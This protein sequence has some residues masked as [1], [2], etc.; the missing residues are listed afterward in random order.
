MS[1]SKIPNFMIIGAAKCGTTTLHHLFSQHPQIYLPQAKETHFFDLDY[2]YEKGKSFYLNTYYSKVN[3]QHK[4]IGDATP[5]YLRFPSKVIPRIK[6]TIGDDD[7]K[8]FVMLR[9]P[10]QR[11]WSHYLHTVRIAEETLDFDEALRLESQRLEENPTKWV[12]YFNDGLYAQQLKPWLEHYPRESFRI[13]KLDDL[14]DNAEETL[15]I[16]FDFLEVDTRTS[17]IDFSGKNLRQTMRSPTLM[18]LIR[19]KFQG[20]Q[21]IK[22]VIPFHI[23]RRIVDNL[24]SINARVV[25]KEETLLGSDLANQLRERYRPSVDELETLLDRDFSQWK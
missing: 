17:S 24:V 13:F 14:K 3:K 21:L 2:Q 9:D 12:G 19:G 7:M 1:N 20:S 18:R 8:F 10:V 15:K 23:R 25:S 5:S 11:A 16:C 4:V 6:S 22:N